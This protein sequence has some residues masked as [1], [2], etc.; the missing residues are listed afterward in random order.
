VTFKVTNIPNI[1]LEQFINMLNELGYQGWDLIILNN[2]IACFKNRN[3]PI[4]YKVVKNQQNDA[5]FIT[6]LNQLGV[7]RWI[8][9]GVRNAYSV[10][11]KIAIQ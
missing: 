1:T 7:D 8:L 5:D 3:V 4:I 9:L 10:F 11:K 6:Q 2:S